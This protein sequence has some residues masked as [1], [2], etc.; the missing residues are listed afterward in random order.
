MYKKLKRILIGTPLASHHEEEQKLNVPLGLAVFAADALS[1]TAYATDEILI[2]IAATAYA[3]QSGLVSL[4]VA[5]AIAVL[6]LLVVVSYRQI[7]RAYP[8]GG[9]A[10]IVARE[11]LGLLP[12]LTAG[13]GLLIDYVLTV[14]VSISAGV[15]AMTSTGLF[16]HE[17]ASGL[18]VTLT[19][20][21]MILNLRGL[22]ESGVVFAVPAYT[23]ILSMLLLLGV[24]LWKLFNGQAPP[25]PSIQPQTG[26][27]SW[28]NT[29]FML[30][31]LKAFSQGCAGLTGI[32]AVSNGVKAFKEPRPELANK[33]MTLMGLLLGGIF[34]GLTFL[35]AGFHITPKA[36]ETI[37]SQIAR[38]VFGGGTPLYFLVQFSTMVLLILAANTAFAGFPSIASLLAQDGYLPR[39]L[40]NRGDRLVY[41]NGIA[42]LAVLAI[43]LIIAYQGNTHALIPLYAV[44]VF[45]CFSLSQSGMVIHHRKHKAPG[46]QSGMVINSLS[47]LVTGMVT[48]ILA[49]EKFLDGAWMI[50]LALPLLVYLF[51]AISRHYKRVE[52]QLTLPH[53]G[54]CPVA[55]EHTALVLVSSLHRGTIPALEYAKTIS[56]QVEAVHVEL[57]A[58]ATARLKAAWEEWGCGIPLTILKSPFRS[59]T[60]PLLEYIDEVEDRYPHDLVTIIVPEFVTKKGWHNL[61]HNQT[62]LLLKTILRFRPGK[63]VT[64]VRYHLAE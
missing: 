41:N 45:I 12:S 62:A 24:G 36:G 14:A 17:Q 47:A 46:W 34:L 43:S 11:N 13:A 30:V 58:Q 29:A 20:L 53:D 26:G 6:I 60:E 59:I 32:E 64:T 35:A 1:S 23:F 16:P 18:G 4:P 55:I 10:Y 49:F 25:L 5:L 40:M 3:A 27:S 51:F 37:V 61:L 2:A 50:F 21:I 57:N 39:Q 42:I 15:A 9:G 63:V 7:I 48:L 31:F 52:A 54:Y 28:L 8:E 33:T 22:R 44:G 19:V 56:E 38:S